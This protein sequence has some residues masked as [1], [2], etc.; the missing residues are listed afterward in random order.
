MR[1][2][3]PLLLACLNKHAFLPNVLT[4]RAISSS[5]TKAQEERFEKSQDDE[6]SAG[7]ELATVEKPQKKEYLDDGD[8]MHRMR[9]DRTGK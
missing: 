9:R 8:D 5:S 4:G 1:I 6:K 7:I 2:S 3:T